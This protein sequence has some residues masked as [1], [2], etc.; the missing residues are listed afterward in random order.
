MPFSDAAMQIAA[1]ALRTAITHAQLHSAA[2]TA[3]VGSEQGTRFAVT[4]GAATAD[5][6]FALTAPVTKTGLTASVAITYVSFWSASSGGTFLGQFALTGD[7]TANAAGEY[8]L[9]AFTANG[10]TT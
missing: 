2:P 8:I 6:D 4:M 5:G 10:S 9:N 1:N 7:L 3:G